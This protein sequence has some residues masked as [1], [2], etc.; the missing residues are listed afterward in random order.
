L[1]GSPIISCPLGLLLVGSQLHQLLG[2]KPFIMGTHA[3]GAPLWHEPEAHAG[4]FPARYGR[5]TDE[6][7]GRAGH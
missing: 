7:P 1:N 6:L 4:D 5:A 3:I 2:G